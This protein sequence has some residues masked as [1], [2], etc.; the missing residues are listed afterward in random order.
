MPDLDYSKFNYILL[1]DVIEHLD[2]PEKFISELKNKIKKNEN[3]K[4]IIST[5]NI[6]FFITRL[7]LLLGSFN[8]G[9]RGILDRTHKRLFTFKSLK[10]LLSQSGFIIKYII[11]IPAPYPLAIG[12]NFF[13][14]LLIKINRYLIYI[15]KGFFSYQIYCELEQEKSLDLLLENAKLRANE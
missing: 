2:N 12:H 15:S 4:L 11:G 10:D 5:P 1:L 8:Y 14:N 9:P 3:L 13:S 6:A 7:M